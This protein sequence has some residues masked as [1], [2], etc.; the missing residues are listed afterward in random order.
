MCACA[1]I[2][3]LVHFPISWCTCINKRSTLKVSSQFHHVG[4][5]YQAQLI[6]RGGN[7]IIIMTIVWEQ[8]LMKSLA[9]SERRPKRQAFLD[10]VF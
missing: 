7:S 4:T 8:L 1:Y 6:N 2:F 3:L 5:Q 10:C 9:V